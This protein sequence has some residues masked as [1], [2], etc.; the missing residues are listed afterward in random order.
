MKIDKRLSN[1]FLKFK[2]QKVFLI[3][4]IILTTL[5]SAFIPFLVMD[6]I[7]TITY[8]LNFSKITKLG[9]LIIAITLI[10]IVLDF[11]QNYY[12][13]KLRLNAVNHL[14]E[15]MFEKMLYKSKEYFDKTSTGKILTMIMDDS[16]IVAQ[17][18]VI[19]MPMLASNIIHLLTVSVVLFILSKQLFL[20]LLI[21]IPI[22]TIVFNKLNSKI[23]NISK[24]ERV[25]FADIMNDAQEKIDGIDTIKVFQREEFMY[26]NFSE[27]IQNHF[28]FVSKNLFYES[29]GRGITDGIIALTP[30]VILLYGSF[31]IANEKLTLGGLMAFY[32]YI[33]YLYEPLMNL[34]D[35]N[36]GRQKAIS[37]GENILNFI[38]IE[39]NEKDGAFKISEFEKLEFKNVCFSY[40]GE[41]DIIKELSFTINKGDKVAIKGGSG[42]GKSTLLKL[43]LRM[44]N[45]TYGNIYINNIDIRDIELSSLYKL[46]SIQVQN[47]FVF[48]GTIEENISLGKTINIEKIYKSMDLGQLNRTLNP[49]NNIKNNINNN[50]LSGGQKQRLCLSRAFLKPFDIL[51]LDEPSSSIDIDLEDNLKSDLK[52]L[53]EEK[54][55][56][57]TS[58]RPSLLELCNKEINLETENKA[59][60]NYVTAH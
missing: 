36:L 49:F 41:S 23:R 45:P 12:W 2:K 42:S 31:L 4:I 11:T 52:K 9:T 5:I 8:H 7:D 57:I 60:N 29:M 37:V 51:I 13:H 19:G 44:Y 33:S 22:Y 10:K 3:I 30:V 38:D 14:R 39:C 32:T 56:I 43:I 21:L 40:K 55:L 53:I 27:K 18:I 6:L 20:V 25:H 35:F 28:K 50:L 26:K 58:H 24:I 47:L 17:N 54:T 59:K 46:F 16:S 1:I 34:S 15:F 48:E